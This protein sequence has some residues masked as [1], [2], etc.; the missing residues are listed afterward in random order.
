MYRVPWRAFKI[1][2]APV[3]G[4]TSKATTSGSPF[5]LSS[6]LSRPSARSL[7][8]IPPCQSSLALR[9]AFSAK[10]PLLSS[11]Q[12]E[13]GKAT[14]SQRRLIKWLIVAGVVGV[15]AVTFSEQ[16]GHAFG[17][18]KRSGRVVGTLAVCINE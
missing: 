18:A 4:K 3:I 14:G 1:E 6:T 9:R 12:S 10:A 8:N 7:Y 5:S 2:P 13:S 17:A 16:A 15:G 11:E